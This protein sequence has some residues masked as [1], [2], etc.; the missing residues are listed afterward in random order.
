MIDTPIRH[1]SAWVLMEVRVSKK[2][3][4]PLIAAEVPVYNAFSIFI[5][6]GNLIRIARILNSISIFIQS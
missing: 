4:E 3:L 2:D 5:S 1:T 6:I